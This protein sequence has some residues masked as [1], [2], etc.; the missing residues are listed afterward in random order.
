MEKM[1]GTTKWLTTLTGVTNSEPTGIK[2]VI[3]TTTITIVKITTLMISILIILLT[4]MVTKDPISEHTVVGKFTIT[5]AVGAR[6]KTITMIPMA[7]SLMTHNYGDTTG[8]QMA[9]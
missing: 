1:Y 9:T 2:Y 5:M 4:H 8:M 7:T 3:H 6:S